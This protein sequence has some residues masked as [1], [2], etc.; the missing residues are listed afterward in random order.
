[1]IAQ[2]VERDVRLFNAHYA[3]NFITYVHRLFSVPHVTC[4]R[5]VYYY[6]PYTKTK[7]VILLQTLWEQLIL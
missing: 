7:N 1:M 6:I 3:M 4:I 2:H 5:R